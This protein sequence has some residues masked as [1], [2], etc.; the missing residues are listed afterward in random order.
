MGFLVNKTC[1]NKVVKEACTLDEKWKVK[2]KAYKKNYH[3]KRDSYK[4]EYLMFIDIET[5]GIL[6]ELDGFDYI[7]NIKQLA[8]I[9]FKTKD[10][11]EN[12]FISDFPPSLL[13]EY[14]DLH[15]HSEY[16]V[17][18]IQIYTNYGYPFIIAHN[19]CA[20]DFKILK[21]HINRYMPKNELKLSYFRTF[22]TYIAIQQML[23]KRR[24]QKNYVKI[25]LKNVSLFM[26]YCHNKY[27]KYSY[28]AN[29]AHQALPDCKMMCL[30][31]HVLR[32]QLDWTRYNGYHDI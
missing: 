22:D 25:S 20:F 26:K 1:P 2:K 14:K 10:Y 27:E 13:Y 11:F 28:L 3:K 23:L 5:D 15:I 32:N 17:K 4:R 31:V 7:P 18:F 29:L 9:M 21:S 16:I 6:G 24:K 8:C 12:D 30:W 19:G